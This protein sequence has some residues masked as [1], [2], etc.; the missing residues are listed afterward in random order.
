MAGVTEQGFTTKTVPEITANLN[1]RF[2]GAFGTQ[3]D[4]S[5]TSPDGQCIGIMAEVLGDMWEKAEAAYNSYSPS[6]TFGIGLDKVVELNGVTRITNRPTSVA[7]TLSGTAG[8][9]VPAGYVIR[10]DDKLDFATVALAVLP[11]I[12]TAVCTTQGAIKIVAGDVHMLSAPIDGLTSAVNL[13]PGITGIVREEDPAL[14]SRREGSTISRG[15]NSKDTIYEAVRA[16]NLPYIRIVENNTN[17]TVDGI[18][19]KSFLTVVEG[20]TPQEVS[21]A[22]Y[23]NKPQGAQAFG[24]IIT[25]ILDSK[26]YPHE[27]GISRPY[28]VDVSMQVSISNLPGASIDSATLAQEALVAHTNNLNISET[29]YWGN[30]FPAIL[31]A[32]PNIKVNS[33]LIK[34]T[35]G[36]TFAMVDL[37]ISAQ[38]RARTDASKVVVNVV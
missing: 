29:V 2:I 5:P 32:V 12:V 13:E 21:R 14:R 20:G 15:T 4:V 16:L 1:S 36:G 6:D 9:V 25:T 28:A 10:T 24:S 35:V 27:I 23:E 8:S 37:P 33:I 26:G 30:L 22:I 38:Q 7:I 3:F 11:A 17:A 18:P 31:S 34:L 19:A